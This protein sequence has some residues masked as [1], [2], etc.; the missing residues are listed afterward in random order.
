MA[1]TIANP[2]VR[3][4]MNN[5]KFVKGVLS[6]KNLWRSMWR[7]MNAITKTGTQRNTSVIVKSVS[8]ARLALGGLLSFATISVFGKILSVAK[9]V[10]SQIGD[11][12]VKGGSEMELAFVEVNKVVELTEEQGKK[13]QKAFLDFADSAPVAVKPNCLA[14]PA[15]RTV[16]FKI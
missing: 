13:L 3:L 1:T 6:T 14:T 9:R 4:D 12:V 11:A 8:I 16:A 7:R 10:F 2:V 15:A 5:A